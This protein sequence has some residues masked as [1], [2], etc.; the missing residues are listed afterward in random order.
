MELRDVPGCSFQ[1][2]CRG[3]HARVSF[4]K[5][6]LGALPSILLQSNTSAQGFPN[7]FSL[8]NLQ[9]KPNLSGVLDNLSNRGPGLLVDHF[10][11]PHTI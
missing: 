9:K 1:K 7:I 4:T 2:A 8:Q 6:S 3:E 5:G 11:F 10:T